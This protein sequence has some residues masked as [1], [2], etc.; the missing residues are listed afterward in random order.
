M[1]VFSRTLLLITFLC[2]SAGAQD[3]RPSTRPTSRPQAKLR[4][5]AARLAKDVATPKALV[6]AVY[7]V[8]SGPRAEKRDWDRMRYL[9]HPSARLV[10]VEPRSGGK[11]EAVVFTVDDYIEKAGPFIE[12]RGFFEREVSSKT[13]RFGP[14]VHVWSTYE[15][16]WKANDKVPF[17]RGI[18]SFQL[19]ESKG[20]WWVLNLSWSPASKGQ[21]LPARYR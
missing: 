18:N 17:V 4:A 15:G 2:L 10:P 21:P 12:S 5:R 7:D 16:R 20:R 8:I 13:E 9:F 3:S 11:V 1:S 19:I 6:A 14:L